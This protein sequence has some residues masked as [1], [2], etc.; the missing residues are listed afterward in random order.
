MALISSAF[1][2]N[3][4]TKRIW[5]IFKK[6]KE[7]YSRIYTLTIP[8]FPFLAQKGRIKHWPIIKVQL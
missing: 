7:K 3:F 8:K 5:R 1:F 6:R 4:M 2:F